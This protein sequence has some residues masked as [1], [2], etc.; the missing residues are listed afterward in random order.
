MDKTAYTTADIQ[1]IF[2]VEEKYKSSLSILNA[3]ERG[4][5]PKANR[6][7]R[8]KTS[9]RQ[10]QPNQ[11][12]DI[13]K[14]FGFLAN[15]KQQ[16]ILNIFL[17]K[18]GVSK[19]TF[20]FNLARIL[21]LC[22][23]KRDSAAESKI[24]IVGL[25]LQGTIT[26]YTLPPI[27]VESLEEAQQTE[28]AGLYEVLYEKAPIQDVILPTDLPN[29]FIIPENSS[30]NSLEKRLRFETRK[31]YV[32]RDKLLP[33]LQDFSV[34]IFDNSPNWNA[35]IENSLVCAT[36]VISPIG[37]ELGSYQALKNHTTNIEEF[38]EA[39]QADWESYFLVPTFLEKSKISQQIYGSYLN[40]YP[41]NV[42]PTPIRRSAVAQ[43]ALALRKSVLEYAP[44]SPIA[45]DY[46]EAIKTLWSKILA[47]EA[48]NVLEA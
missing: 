6:L 12:P 18:G 17:S 16:Q 45:D 41:E 35:L 34:I 9:V 22:S 15:S 47:S 33:Q 44:T 43:E 20:G 38:S 11:L 26:D 28:R 29:L 39:V 5:I 3:E 7:Q 13:G 25:D 8:G 27:A 42:L 37:C 31:E 48:A 46:Y 4:E 2:R 23:V 1:K 19:S 30:L 36:T 21:S 10:W 40:Q 24:L 14:K 32:F